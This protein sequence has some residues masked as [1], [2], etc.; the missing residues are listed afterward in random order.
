MIIRKKE[1]K[2]WSCGCEVPWP[3]MSREGKEGKKKPWSPFDFI[4]LKIS[5][6]G[7]K[8]ETHNFS[9]LLPR[10][11]FFCCYHPTTSIHDLRGTCRWPWTRIRLMSERRHDPS[12]VYRHYPNLNSSPNCPKFSNNRCCHKLQG[13]RVTSTCN[14]WTDCGYILED[15]RKRHINAWYLSSYLSWS[16]LTYND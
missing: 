9:C 1:G 6:R 15:T 13:K 12:H 3:A 4:F 2:K 16:R 10:L 8:L 7:N 14:E 5:S 11:W